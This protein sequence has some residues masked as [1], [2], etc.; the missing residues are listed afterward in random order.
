MTETSAETIQKTHQQCHTAFAAGKSKSFAWRLEQL[1]SLER[2]VIEQE[3]QLAEALESDLG[4]SYTE[5]WLYEIS[6]VQVAA[7]YARKNLSR[8]MRDKPVFTPAF[9][10]PG[11]SWIHYEPKGVVLIIAPWN[12]PLQLCLAPLVS[13]ISA[14]NCAVIKPSELAPATSAA[15]AQLLPQYLDNECIQVVEG[16]VETSTEVLKLPWDHI[17]YTGGERV[18][19]IVMA[20]ASRHLTPVTLELGGKSP[21]VVLADADLDTAARRIVWGRFTNSGQ[22]CVA[23]DHILTDSKTAEALIPKLQQEITAM[24]G[25]DPQQSDDYGRIVSN[26]HFERVSGLIEQDKAVV[27]GESDSGDRYIAPTVL[28]PADPSDPGMRDEIFGPLLPV[29]VMDNLEQSIEFIRSG[30]KPLAAYLF[31]KNRQA[32]EDFVSAVSAGNICINDVMMFVAVEELPFRGVGASGNGSYKGEHGFLE[33]SHQ[34]SVLKRTFW[35]DLRMRY[36][37]S[38]PG[39]LKW[40]RWFR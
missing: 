15:L 18:A 38:T 19:K 1:E 34:K 35:P 11:K 40:L 17:V 2:M 30:P 24:F 21:C 29:L 4:K 26:E 36:A 37:P 6:Y 28:Y 13:A 5:A 27:G 14:G 8:W 3:K 33:L 22:T 25:A 9:A 31:S 10:M 23:P 32:R 16:G 12:Y 39:K 7:S 20:A